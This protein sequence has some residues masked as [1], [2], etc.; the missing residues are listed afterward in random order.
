MA[1]QD[2]IIRLE[3]VRF[4]TGS[5]TLLEDISCKIYKGDRLSLVGHSGSGKTSLLRLLNRLSETS[6]GKIFFENQDIQQLPVIP[7]RQQVMLVPQESRLLGMTVR[8]ALTYPLELRGIAQ[9]QQRISTWM[10]RLRI[11]Q[12]WLDKLEVQLSVGQRQWV[13]I[14]R[15]LVTQPKVLL[16]DEPTSAL[17]AG[18]AAHLLNVLTEFA[19][20]QQTAILMVNHQLDLAQQFGDRVLHLQQGRLI[21]NLPSKQINWPELQQTLIQAETQSA[22]EWE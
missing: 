3:G 19:Q 16:L 22:Q 4:R 18:R 5:S 1:G 2:E 21:Q 17:D 10:E 11:P 6:Q 15:A 7:L 12:D 20:T 14:A 13:A 9:P 8:Q